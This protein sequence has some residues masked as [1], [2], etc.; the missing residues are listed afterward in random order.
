[1][2]NFIFIFCMSS[3]GLLHKICT[4]WEKTGTI[5]NGLYWM[6]NICEHGL[7]HS[8]KWREDGKVKGGSKM[9]YVLSLPLPPRASAGCPVNE[10]QRY[11]ATSIPVA[12]EQHMLNKCFADRFVRGGM[13]QDSGYGSSRDLAVFWMCCSCSERRQQLP[14]SYCTSLCC[15]TCFSFPSR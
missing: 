13:K 5:A 15:I 11:L 10:A 8:R 1:M 4:L 3:V 7:C 12:W 9:P 14:V 6:Q 2:Q